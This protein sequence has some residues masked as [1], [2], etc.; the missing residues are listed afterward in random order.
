MVQYLSEMQQVKQALKIIASDKRSC[1]F[2]PF[3]QDE[4]EEKGF[5]ITPAP[6]LLL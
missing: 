1:L 6:V 2:D 3:V 4:E 5:L